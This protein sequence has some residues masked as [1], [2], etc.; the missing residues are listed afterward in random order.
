MIASAEL[1]L[2]KFIQISSTLILLSKHW[3]NNQ[4]QMPLSS[5]QINL[6]LM[7]YTRQ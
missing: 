5:Q 4:V 3:E 1:V 2:S 6:L 7:Q